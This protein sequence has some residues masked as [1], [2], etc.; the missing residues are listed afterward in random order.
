MKKTLILILL[1]GILGLVA[2]YFL[3]GKI[4]DEYVSL[5]T[6]FSNSSN[7]IESLGRK[8][9]GIEKMKQNILISGGVGGLLGLI[10]GFRKK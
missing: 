10:I 5:K 4:G 7:A 2:G 1:F 3:F 9:S 6:I 8:I